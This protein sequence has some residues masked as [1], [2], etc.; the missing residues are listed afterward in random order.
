VGDSA[1][2]QPSAEEPA[3]TL[4]ENFVRSA[5][6]I[7]ARD[8]RLAVTVPTGYRRLNQDDGSGGQYRLP[9]RPAASVA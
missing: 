1:Q 4:D 9:V 7:H 6:I 2:D 5:Q 8:E 3:F